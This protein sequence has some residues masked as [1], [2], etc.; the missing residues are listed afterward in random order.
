[1]NNDILRYYH[2]ELNY[3]RQAGSDFA[4]HHPKTA[5]LLRLDNNANA[6]PFVERLLESFAFLTANIQ[7]QFDQGYKDFAEQI[8][9]LL[10][11][12]VLLP[13]PAMTTL[14]LSAHSSLKQALLVPRHT[15]LDTIDKIPCRFQTCYDVN[16]LPLD[17]CAIHYRP[18]YLEQKRTVPVPHCKAY[19]HLKL[20]T[21]QKSFC[22]DA[23]SDSLRFHI[24]PQQQYSNLLYHYLFT[25]CRHIGWVTANEVQTLA[26]T[27]Q[28]CWF[29]CR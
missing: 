16:L 11:P 22:F 23:N 26:T 12:E 9:T 10:Y 25:A 6:D 5:S 7:Q 27:L 8:L 28:T 4:R 29:C 24:N 20:K 15:E 21:Q 3:L 18:A 14:K 13:I 19:L 2:D 1:M 17:I